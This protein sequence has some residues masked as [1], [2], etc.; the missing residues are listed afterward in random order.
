MPFCRVLS[1]RKKIK[2]IMNKNQKTIF[3][4]ILATLCW[5][6]TF[7]FGKNLISN[8]LIDPYS[9]VFFRFFIGGV[10]TLLIAI[11]SKEKIS[12]NEFIGKNGFLLLSSS[13][14]LYFAMSIFLFVGQRYCNATTA[15]IFLES[16]PV[17]LLLLIEIIIKRKFNLDKFL[18]VILGCLGCL[19]VLK[20]ANQSFMASIS[21]DLWGLTALLIS[22]L[23]WVM[24][25]IIVKKINF[26]K[27]ITAKTAIMQ[28]FAAIF[29]LPLLL[30]FK[31]KLIFIPTFEVYFQ[32]I[33]MSI[34]PTAA[35]FILWNIAIRSGEL[36]LALMC[37]NMTPVFT[38]I[39]AYFLLN[40]KLDL[41]NLIGVF[42]VIS[43][44]GISQF[45]TGRKKHL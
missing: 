8:N 22:A 41:I 32:V 5:S 39:F 26:D 20:K 7:L 31:T 42:I 30:F 14:F 25:S 21:V 29:C 11:V 40:E 36:Y 27:N 19:L 45:L 35:A 9:L 13:F 18:I 4:G 12:K 10:F 6:S 28:L 15:A 33:F 3:Y 43:T 23:S 38:I 24:G 16:M 2:L 37:Q 17:V 34:F 44:L 1:I